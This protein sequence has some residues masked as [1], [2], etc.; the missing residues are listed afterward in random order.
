MMAIALGEPITLTTSALD[1]LIFLYVTAN[2]AYMAIL[3]CG[4]VTA[5]DMALSYMLMMR[6]IL[7]D[8]FNLKNNLLRKN[9]LIKWYKETLGFQF[10]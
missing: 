5:A 2:I 10:L 1:N 8:F 9:Q 6:I 7:S 3:L 4:N